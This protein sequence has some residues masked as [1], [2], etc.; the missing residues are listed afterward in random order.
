[1]DASFPS[2]QQLA[3][4]GLGH[5]ATLLTLQGDDTSL[6]NMRKHILGRLSY[7]TDLLKNEFTLTLSCLKLNPK[8]YGPWYHRYWTVQKLPSL[9]EIDWHLE[10]K[11]IMKL[12]ELDSR[13]CTALHCA[14]LLLPSCS[15]S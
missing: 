8:S 6:W 12:L 5:L 13:N 11:L 15:F 10:D 14:F 1:M 7:P 2:L 4:E 9:L 3:T